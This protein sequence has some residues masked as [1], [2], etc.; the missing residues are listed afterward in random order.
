MTLTGISQKAATIGFRRENVASVW[1]EIQPLLARHALEVAHFKDIPL[2]P[3]EN[4]YYA[5]EEK[6][7]ARVYTARLDG[8]TQALVGYSVFFVRRSMHYDSVQAQND[9]IF[10]QPEHRGFG[11]RFITW[12]DEQLRAEGVQAVR[13]H[14]K[15]A[16]NWGRVIER[17]GYELEDLIYVKRLDR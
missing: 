3:D 9:I 15:A 1:Y 5:M 6:G 4:L 11:A 10:I 8:T 16:H 13:H 14:V 7:L 17:Q 12:C 2:N